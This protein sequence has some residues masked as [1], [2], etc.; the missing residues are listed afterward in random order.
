LEDQELIRKATDGSLED[1]QKSLDNL[2]AARAT[3]GSHRSLKI[4]TA[5]DEVCFY[6]LM[7]E[8]ELV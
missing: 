7:L 4:A 3:Q 8:R 1:F 5:L 2:S 6:A